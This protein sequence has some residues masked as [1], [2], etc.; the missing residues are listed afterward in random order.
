MAT[1][2]AWRMEASDFETGFDLIALPSANLSF[3]S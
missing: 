2:S 3:S 1:V